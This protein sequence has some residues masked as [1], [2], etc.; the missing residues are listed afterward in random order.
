MGIDVDYGTAFGK[1]QAAAGGALP[2]GVPIFTTYAA[3]RAVADGLRMSRSTRWQARSL[4]SLYAAALPPA[5]V[6]THA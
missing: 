3:A 6:L 2:N 4:Q 5:K 1:S